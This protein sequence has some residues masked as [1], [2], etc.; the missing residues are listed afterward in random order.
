MGLLR[1]LPRSGCHIHHPGPSAL[2][3]F[4][5]PSRAHRHRCGVGDLGAAP[6]TYWVH[7]KGF[8]CGNVP[9][10]DTRAWSPAADNS[11]FYHLAEVS[12]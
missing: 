8:P 5:S 9:T 12:P 10:W 2:S 6:T 1:L 3:G 7:S 4:T 11:G